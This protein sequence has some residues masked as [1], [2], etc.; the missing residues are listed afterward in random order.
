MNSRSAAAGAYHRGV[1]PA[2]SVLIASDRVETLLPECLRSLDGQRGGPEFEAVVCSAQPPA[3]D[4]LAFPVRWVRA[5]A[6]NPAR[7]RNAAARRGPGKRP[8]VPRRRRH[9]RAGLA[10]RGRRAPAPSADDRRRARS[11]AARRA[12]RRAARPT[13]F[14]RHPGS[15]AACPRTSGT[16]A[17]GRC[18]RRT[19]S[20]SATSSCGASGSRRSAGF[21]ESFG[22]IGEDTDFVRRALDGGARVVLD[23]SVRVR[24]R[25]RAFPGPYLAQRWRYRVKTGRLLVEK[26]GLHARGRVATFLAAAFAASAGA[27]LLGHGGSSFPPRPATR[28]SPGRS[29]SRSGAATSA[30]FPAVP[31]AFAVHHATYFAGLLAGIGRGRPGDGGAMKSSRSP[32]TGCGAGRRCRATSFSA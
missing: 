26:P 6:R 24:H 29:P 17:A 30:L 4:G 21:D 11:G 8:R 12:L 20:R 25:R 9:G 13:C 18:G 19:T 16:R 22:Y 15:A 31:F 23:P 10:R 32:R 2:V 5:D 14:S 28:S 3:V 7:R 1:E 27:A